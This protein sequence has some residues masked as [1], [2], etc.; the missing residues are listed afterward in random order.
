MMKHQYL[1][2]V[3][4][5]NFNQDL[6]TGCSRCIEVCPHAVF[7]RHNKKVRIIARDNCIEC[8]ACMMNCSEGALNVR[9][10]VGYA[11]AIIFSYFSKN[12]GEISCTC[13]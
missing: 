4:T 6:C 5:L 7:E 11:T 8:G 9:A 12:K 1:K 2:N 3:V 13:C 10:G